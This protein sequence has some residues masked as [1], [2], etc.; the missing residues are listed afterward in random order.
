MAT[1]AEKRQARGQYESYK[2]S[3]TYS[4]YE[5]YG[6]H[7]KAKADAWAY[8]ERLMADYNGYGLKVISHNGYM[9]T[10]GFEYE[11]EGKHMFMYITRF[12]DIAV[13]VA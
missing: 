13:E 7:S 3:T 2:R 6:R 8:C 11:Y 10:A 9:F 4:L 5:A 12:K 1:S